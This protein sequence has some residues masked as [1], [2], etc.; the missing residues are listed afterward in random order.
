MSNEVLTIDET[1]VTEV[2]SKPNNDEFRSR[3]MNAWLSQLKILHPHIPDNLLLHILKTYDEKPHII[4]DIVEEDK[5][6]PIK[7]KP[8]PDIQ[9]VYNTV[10]VV[11]DDE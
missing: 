8:R 6:C 3:H 4:D 7:P 11:K 2:K 10:D 9:G 5:K 1:D